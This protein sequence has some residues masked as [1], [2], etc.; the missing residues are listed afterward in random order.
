M[1]QENNVMK[2]DNL[3]IKII[4]IP[5]LIF[6]YAFYGFKFIT[7]DL[8][9]AENKKVN[10]EN[11][12]DE[13]YFKVKG[14]KEKERVEKKYSKRYLASLEKEKALLSKDLVEAGA[15]RSSSQILYL[16]KAKDTD[17]NIITDTIKAFSKLDVNTYLINE[18]F[19]VYS[20]KNSKW[21]EFVHQ[22]ASS[23]KLSTKEVLFFLTQLSTYVKAGMSVSESIKVLQKQVVSNHRKSKLYEA[24]NF[25]LS[26]GENF[27]AALEKQGEAFPP[28][29]VNMIKAAEASGTLNDT[30]DDMTNYYAQ[31]YSTKKQMFSAVAYPMTI[32]IFSFIVI[33]FILIYV[34]PQ[35]TSIYESNS[36]EVTGITLAVISTSDFLKNNILYVVLGII[37]FI[38]LFVFLFKNSKSFKLNVQICLMKIP[39]I[40][41]IIIYNEL[42]IFS[43]T[44]SSLL[45]NGVFITDSVD[46]LCKITSNEVYKTIHA[47]TIDNVVKGKKFSEA[48]KDHWAVPDV[49]YHMIV[50][51]EE[52]GDLPNMMGKVSEYYQTMH[53]AVV[54]NLKTLIEPVLTAFLAIIVGIIIIAVIVPMYGIYNDIS[55]GV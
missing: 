51:G 48:F 55:G 23:S 39:V 40:K 53:K 2:K 22:E 16:Y 32:L 10:E 47:K 18:G 4:L 5:F 34:V 9:T 50:T 14:S 44:F 8:F 6:K 42:I 29:L 21:I 12:L 26:L 41:D 13:L 30:L 15:T 46:I 28:L 38:G 33:S 27:S 54:N 52:T 19:E 36:S 7:F 17:G 45:K 43:K 25:E 24:I 35:F 3:F 49:A 37:I 31:L 11:V 1:M 20:I